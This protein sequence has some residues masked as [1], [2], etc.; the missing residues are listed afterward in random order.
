MAI[1]FWEG[2]FYPSLVFLY[3]K[4][5]RNVTLFC[6]IFFHTTKVQ[7]FPETAKFFMLKFILLKKSYK[8]FAY[9]KTI[10][11]LCIIKFKTIRLWKI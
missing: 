11:Y 9:M 8:T 5:G 1:K 10:S 3:K 7:Q 6:C 2:V 4:S